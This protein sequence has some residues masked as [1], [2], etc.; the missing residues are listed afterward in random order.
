MISAF[1]YVDEDIELIFK[2]PYNEAIDEVWDYYIKNI[3]NR[4]PYIGGDDVSGTFNLVGATQQIALI[5]VGE[6]YGM[7]T[8]K[9]GELITESTE[10][11]FKNKRLKM[12]FAKAMFKRPK[13]MKFIMVKAADKNRKNAIKN[14]GSFEFEV[15][16]ST[17][18]YPIKMNYTVCPIC[19]F[20]KKYD[21][22]EYMPYLCNLDYTIFKFFGVSLYRENTC[23][24]GDGY[25][26]FKI[27]KGAPIPSTWPPHILD[28]NDPLK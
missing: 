16:E 6:T 24:D 23:A 28:M 27:K 3:L 12:F 15:L 20:A 5:K 21:Y 26:D 13:L 10:L 9:W 8:T 2:K 19:E 25:C 1:K 11:Y 14:P 4:L 17:D 22:M 7:T 18:E